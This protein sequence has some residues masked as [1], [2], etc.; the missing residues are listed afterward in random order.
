MELAGFCWSLKKVA[1][2]GVLG[3]LAAPVVA[4]VATALALVVAPAKGESDVIEQIKR[5]GEL[6]A[7]GVLSDE[8]FTSEKTDV[9]NRL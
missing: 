2:P 4:P 9:L 6:H 3:G 7:S 8:E 5:L 1:G